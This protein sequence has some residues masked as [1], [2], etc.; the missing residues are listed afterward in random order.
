MLVLPY[1]VANAR[2]S[3]DMRVDVLWQIIYFVIAAFLFLVVPFA[4][5]YYESDV[6]PELKLGICDG[7]LFTAI[8]FTIAFFI[9]FVVLL[10]V[11]YFLGNEA[12]VPVNRVAIA[13]PSR[14]RF[15]E[16]AVPLNQSAFFCSPPD[17]IETEFR[18]VIP[19]TFPVY[20]IAFVAWLGWW[21]FTLFVGVGFVSTP[22]DLIN[23]FRTRPTPMKAVEH[24]ERRKELGRRAAALIQAGTSLYKEI[25]EPGEKSRKTKRAQE[26]LLAKFENAYYFLKKDVEVLKVA[27]ELKGGNPIW[28][29]FKLVLGLCSLVLSVTWIIHIGIFVLPRVPVHPFLNDFFITLESVGNGNFP[30]FGIIAYA[31]YSFYLIFVCVQGNFKLGVRLL[32]IRIFPMELHNT[33]MNAFLFNVWILLFCAVPTVQFCVQSFPV[34]ARF[35]SIDLLLGVQAQHLAFFREFWEN[36]VFIWMLVSVCFLTAIWLVLHPQD[37]RKDIE[38]RLEAIAK[39]DEDDDL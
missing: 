21:F 27:Y 17:C 1:D 29:V 24:L 18:W 5:F 38:K 28:Y 8:K 12:R 3:G 37:K 20:I 25:N 30:L 16:G 6:D 26:Q 14:D 9:T 13:V 32:W 7:Q 33:M 22:M 31:I 19:V 2:S 11:A 23:E 4:F 39:G 10:L 35:T 34:Y 36:D 15:F